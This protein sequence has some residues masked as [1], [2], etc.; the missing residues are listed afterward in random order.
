MTTPIDLDAVRQELYAVTSRE[1]A[2]L[3]G[4]RLREIGESLLERAEGLEADNRAWVRCAERNGWRQDVAV[5]EDIEEILCEFSDDTY[6][7]CG[8]VIRLRERVAVFEAAVCE[9]AQATAFAAQA[10][11]DQPHI[12]GLLKLVHPH[13]P[14]TGEEN[15]S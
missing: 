6:D 8:E 14:T 1:W 5:D 15:E 11:L 10:W 4:Q 9:F 7:V 13:P 3:G 2:A 12:A